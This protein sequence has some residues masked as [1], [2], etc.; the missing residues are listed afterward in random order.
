MLEKLLHNDT[1][2]KSLD[3]VAVAARIQYRDT[4]DELMRCH[5][6]G[7]K[8]GDQVHD[9]MTKSKLTSLKLSMPHHLDLTTKFTL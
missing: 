2:T 3:H 4:R 9:N 5:R 8:V 6:G 7:F 1:Y